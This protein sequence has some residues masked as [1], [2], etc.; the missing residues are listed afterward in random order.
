M[1]IIDF[2]THIYPNKIAEKA[3]NAVADFYGITP[4]C[5]GSTEEL[6]REGNLSIKEISSL[7]GYADP[8][9]FSRLFKKQTEMTPRE[10]RERNNV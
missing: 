2:H 8:N 9:Y 1:K 5:I 4:A 3:T 7:V 6:L 10:Y